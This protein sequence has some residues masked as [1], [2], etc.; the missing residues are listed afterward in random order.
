MRLLK[1]AEKTFDFS[2]NSKKSG[3]TVGFVPTMG[4]LHNGHL[5]LIEAC[6]QKCDIVVC[7]IFVNPTQFN[8][9]TDLEKY[10]R[11]VDKDILM[12]FNAGCDILFLPNVEDIYPKNY[13]PK[14]YNLGFL[15][16]VLEGKYRPGHF[17][18]VCQVLDELFKIVAPNEVFFGQKDYQQC[19][20]V[21]Q[22]LQQTP[23]F[24]NIKM[25]IAPTLRENSG[26]AM[27]S[28]NTRLNKDETDTAAKIFQ[29]LQFIKQQLRPGDLKQL[30]NDA[31]SMLENS[32]FKVDY[33]SIA[34]AQTLQEVNDWNG[35]TPLVA[36]VAAY[37]GDV[38]LIDNLILN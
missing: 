29:T 19:M 26:L 8:N 2:N 27:S 3:Q 20:V 28:R 25:N 4:A 37:L 30:K 36:L 38:R 14:H 10:P 22:L 16:T 9:K 33:V 23:E 11:T 7:S 6:R 18:G 15:E 35:N 32:A 12:L 1:K 34:N 21:K 13:M 24:K 5:K 31:Q 17:Q